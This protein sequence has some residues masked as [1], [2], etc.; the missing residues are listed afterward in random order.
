MRAVGARRVIP[1]HWDNFFRPLDDGLV[2]NADFPR[3][4]NLLQERGKADNIDIRLSP[5]W[6]P[7]DPFA[8][9]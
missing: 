5:Q 6:L 7:V 2:T 8:G 9:L 4:M 3:M 1:I